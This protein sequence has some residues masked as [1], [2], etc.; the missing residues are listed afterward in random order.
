MGFF[1]L[2][3]GIIHSTVASRR[4]CPGQ[5]KRSLLLRLGTPC[6]LWHEAALGLVVKVFP[7]DILN[8]SG[9]LGV[10]G[11]APLPTVFTKRW[12][13][14]EVKLPLQKHTC[15]WPTDRTV[16]VLS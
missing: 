1:L 11:L 8:K 2:S 9:K 15:T 13:F 16:S 14:G 12:D 10:E 4:F 3:L 5:T 6:W 7:Q